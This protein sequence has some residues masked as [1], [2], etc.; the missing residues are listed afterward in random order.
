MNHWQH[1]PVVKVVRHSVWRHQKG[2]AW[3]RV[4]CAL[5]RPNTDESHWRQTC[6]YTQTCCIM[7]QGDYIKYSKASCLHR[8]QG[9]SLNTDTVLIKQSPWPINAAE[10]TLG[11]QSFGSP[12]TYHCSPSVW[13]SIL[14]RETDRN[15]SL[16]TSSIPSNHWVE[17]VWCTYVCTSTRAWLCSCV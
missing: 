2:V 15:R 12:W 9:V 5:D 14:S 6:M 10:A 4:P 13:I 8:L 3:G 1:T 11:P 17:C 16:I 7:E